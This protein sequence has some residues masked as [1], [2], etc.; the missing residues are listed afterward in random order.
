[1]SLD[2]LAAD[3][4]EADV[5]TQVVLPLLTKSEYLSISTASVRSKEFLTAFDIGKGAKLRKAYIPDFGIYV[6]SLPVVV[7]EVKAPTVPVTEAWEEASLYA[8]MLNRRYPANINPCELILATNGLDFIAGRWDSKPELNGKISDLLLGSKLLRQLQ[9]LMGNAELARIA[10]RTSASLKLVNFKRPFNQGGGAALIGSKLELNTF[11]ADLSP[12]LRRYF[13]SRDQNK[14]PEI[15]R[16]AYV[17]SDEVTSYDKTLESFLIDRLSRSRSRIEIQTTKRKAEDVS[18]RLTELAA[19]RLAGGELQLITGGV[20]TG[21]SLFA[22]RYKEFLQPQN[23]RDRSHW[24]FLDF[25]FAPKRLENGTEWVFSTFCQSLLEEGAPVNLRDADDQE[26]VFASDMKDR[27]PFYQRV[28]AADHGRGL[29]ERARDLEGWRQDPERLAKGLSRYLQGERGDILIVVFDNVD[30]RDVEDQLAAF[31]LALWFMDQIRCLVILQMRDT[32]FETHKNEPPLDTYKTGQVFHISPPRFIDVVKRRLELSV[33]ELSTYAPETIRFQTPSGANISYPRERAGEFLKGI[34]LELFQRPTNTSRILEALAGRNVRKALDMFLSIITSGHMPEDLITSVALGSQIRKFPEYLVLRI[35]MRQDYR[36]YSDA[37][38]F[39]ANIFY[40]D[41]NW[42]R[43]TNLLVPE[44]L[45]YL[46]GRRKMNGDNGLMGFLSF[47]RISDQME[48]FGYVGEDV[49][50]AISYLLEHELAEADSVN[51]TKID[52]ATSIKATASGWAHL[53]LLSS[54]SEYLSGLLP[55][56]PI[57][58]PILEARVFDLMQLENKF[59]RLS[60]EQSVGLVQQFYLYLGKQ[61]DVLKAHPGYETDT[62]SG[63]KY[64]LEK[65]AEAIRFERKSLSTGPTQLDW[66]DR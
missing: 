21:K 51:A 19:T 60:H 13:S 23:L 15:Y 54:R 8:H 50:S 56:T 14:D 27:E 32:T 25:N 37:N 4:S 48:M 7:I 65:V 57:N 10:E 31:Q 49:R 20:G 18:R 9:G 6:L 12:V 2:M 38:G 63:A 29:L 26:R 11:A 5:E 34:Y 16:S 59:G 3:A 33:Q 30:R 47:S 45:F 17:S 36:F 44:I 58:D 40:C 1:M 43:P 52:D 28:E 42:R 61:Y 35:L 41:A 62:L 64:V 46:I 55:T 22:R 39:V 53:R 24:A 66:L